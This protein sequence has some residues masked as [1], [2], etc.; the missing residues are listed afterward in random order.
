MYNIL[1]HANQ[2]N[3]LTNAQKIWQKKKKEKRKKNQIDSYKKTLLNKKL[4]KPTKLYNLFEKM[5]VLLVDPTS[6][7]RCYE[8]MIRLHDNAL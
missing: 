7:S 5:W 4:V 8:Q 6:G 2:Q 3:V 1:C